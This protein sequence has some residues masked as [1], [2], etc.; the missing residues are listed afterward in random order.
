[1]LFKDQLHI[2]FQN[3]NSDSIYPY[4]M[5]L[6]NFFFSLFHFL[7]LTFNLFLSLPGF[8]FSLSLSPYLNFSLLIPIVPSHSPLLGLNSTISW[9][10][11]SL[12]TTSLAQFIGL[13]AYFSFSNSF[14]K[15]V[16]TLSYVHLPVLFSFYMLSL[17][18]ST[19][20]MVLT[21]PCMMMI[22]KL[23]SLYLNSL[24]NS[25]STVLKSQSSTEIL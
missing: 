18:D 23:M 9:F 21:I 15:P 5:L 3:S 10:S 20:V 14:L 19:Q 8:P 1:M 2:S 7:V 4:L 24:L 17:R 16:F 12:I 6:F 11:S 25:S 22:L 13:I